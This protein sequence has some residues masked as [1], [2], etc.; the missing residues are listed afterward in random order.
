MDSIENIE[1]ISLAYDSALKTY[2]WALRRIEA[3]D[4]NLHR[5]LAIGVPISF[6]IIGSLIGSIIHAPAPSPIKA[7]IEAGLI[8]IACLFALKA[9]RTALRGV[10][11]DFVTVLSPETLWKNC[12][13]PTKRD[14]QYTEIMN[15]QEHLDKNSELVT[16][17]AKAAKSSVIAFMWFGLLAIFV[18]EVVQF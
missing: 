17:K 18:W 9:I 4:A 6:T 10:D 1:N 7:V 11:G 5:I 14:Y 16:M 2:D 12:S 13:L 8:L 3:W 15:A